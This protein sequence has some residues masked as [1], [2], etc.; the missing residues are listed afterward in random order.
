M[1]GLSLDG[2]D[3]STHDSFRN[4]AGNFDRVIALLNLLSQW[5]VP[6]IVRSILAKPNYESVPRIGQILQGLD[7]VSRWS[8]L[9]F[10]P[11]GE[12]Y[13]NSKQYD[14]AEDEF[15]RVSN[16]IQS[17]FHTPAKVN[18]YRAEDKVGTYALVTPSGEVYGTSDQPENGRFP[19]IG[20]IIGDHLCT[21]A[22]RLPF[23]KEHHI[24][25]YGTA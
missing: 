14:L 5:Q 9:Q 24:R 16:Q 3:A 25:R 18:I 13:R 1:V 15:D 17:G 7:N 22:S 11:V 4:K 20:S 21:L 10:S 23:S 8:I 19:T 2:P 12:G 6:V